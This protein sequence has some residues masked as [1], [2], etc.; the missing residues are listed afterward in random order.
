MDG[1]KGAA[2]PPPQPPPRAPYYHLQPTDPTARNY[3]AQARVEAGE[4]APFNAPPP[5]Q[6]AYP[7]PLPAEPDAKR[8]RV[9]DTCVKNPK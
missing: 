9:A 5:P 4:R 1:Q 3:R 2:Q 8:P 7:P 6:H